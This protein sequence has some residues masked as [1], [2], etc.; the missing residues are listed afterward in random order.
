[1]ALL[2]LDSSYF[3]VLSYRDRVL[4]HWER[5]AEG[6]RST[7]S[8]HLNELERCRGGGYVSRKN[9]LALDA[10]VAK[11]GRLDGVAY[12]YVQDPKDQILATSLQPLPAELKESAQ[13]QQT[14]YLQRANNKRAR[15][16]SL[17]DPGS[18]S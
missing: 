8:G 4:P 11:Y 12:A 3:W 17:R 14:T 2:S 18:P 13:V 1:L 15:E 7:F 10:F 6:G 5:A 16:V 9:G